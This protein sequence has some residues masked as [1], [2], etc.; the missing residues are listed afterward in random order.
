[1]SKAEI[2]IG[3]VRYYAKPGEVSDDWRVVQE[4]D[5][6][7]ICG[8]YVIQAEDGRYYVEYFTSGTWANKLIGD[9]IM[10]WDKKQLA[11]AVKLG[12]LLR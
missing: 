3:Q 5:G 6:D 11:L 2:Q 9:L 10:S 7:R 4:I 12:E 8:G 1:M